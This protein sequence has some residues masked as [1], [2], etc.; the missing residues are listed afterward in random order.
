MRVDARKG[1]GA[2]KPR[3][4]GLTWNAFGR[5]VRGSL[6]SPAPGASWVDQAAPRFRD[7]GWSALFMR[8]RLQAGGCA[9]SHEELAARRIAA[10]RFDVDL[11]HFLS[12]FHG[13][14]SMG[15]LSDRPSKSPKNRRNFCGLGSRAFRATK[16]PRAAGLVIGRRRN[17]GERSMNPIPCAAPS[18]KVVG[19]GPGGVD[20]ACEPR[21]APWTQPPPPLRPLPASLP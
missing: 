19:S 2:E 4:V 18:W 6:G 8:G 13:S 3:D 1:K 12:S 14:F 11:L 16:S 15:P 7:A 20:V 10:H 5:P 17:A 9:T 21:T